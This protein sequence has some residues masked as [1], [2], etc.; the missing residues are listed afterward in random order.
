MRAAGL[1]PLHAP[2]LLAWLVADVLTCCVVA[3]LA[4]TKLYEAAANLTL[5]E[6][7]TADVCWYL[8]RA[9]G[10]FHNP[11]DKVGFESSARR[12]G[13]GGKGNGVDR[14]C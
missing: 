1:G 13:K 3:G 6:Q 5:F 10:T 8:M 2:W 4:A 12:V 14:R 7:A 11:F 9:D